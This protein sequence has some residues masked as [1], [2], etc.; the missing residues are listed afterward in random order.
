MVFCIV[1]LTFETTL[2]FYMK[3]E[4]IF[5]VI[6]LQIIYRYIACVSDTIISCKDFFNVRDLD[7]NSV[8]SPI[9]TFGTAPIFLYER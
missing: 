9:L 1:K 4:A 5:K 7:K 2:T 8:L 3:A 6:F